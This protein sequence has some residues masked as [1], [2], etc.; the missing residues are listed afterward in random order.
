MTQRLIL[1]RGLPGSGKS[2]LAKQMVDESKGGLVRIERD[3][4][5][6]QL[7]NSRMYVAPEG[8]SPE[9]IQAVKDY[10]SERENT[11]TTVQFSAAEGALREGKDVILSD[12]NLRAK[13]VKDWMAFARKWSVEFETILFDH[14]SVDE[15]V[16]RDKVRENSIG[17]K[18]IRDMA[19]RFLVKGKIPEV[20]PSD[21]NYS[22]VMRVE[23]YDNPSNLPSAVVVD[24]DGT[25]ATMSDR[26][27][28]DWHRVGEDTPVAA[29]ISAVN[30]AMQAGQAIIVMSGRDGSCYDI[31]NT[32]LLKHLQH[33]FHLFMRVEGDNRKD[34]IVKY[35]LF[36]QH[37]RGKYHVNY[38]LD[39]RDQVVK[40]WRELGLACFQVNYGAF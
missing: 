16:C 26:S 23:P 28:Y 35:D 25:L 17:E 31:T 6:D 24:I 12:T 21:R 39:D 38:V 4:L 20:V 22:V 33:N 13:Y 37:I 36:N 3:L 29:V 15:C 5:R 14:V 9:E 10:V 34:N 27:P 40:M 2:T 32:W 18:I 19:K 1:T 7:Y 11:I 30:A 8:S